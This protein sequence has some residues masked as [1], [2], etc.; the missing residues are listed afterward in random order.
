MNPNMKRQRARP[1]D[2]GSFP[3][4]HTGECKD[5]MLKYMS[6]LKEN[7]SDH[8]QC[9]VLAKDYLQCRMECELMTKEEWGKLGYKDIEQE[10]NNR[11]EQIMVV[12]R[13]SVAMTITIISVIVAIVSVVVATTSL[14]SSVVVSVST[15]K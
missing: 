12:G 7:S 6:C 2:K 14:I 4:D 9:R 15:E 5:H 8:S 1:P 10:N 11:R 13:I 3:L